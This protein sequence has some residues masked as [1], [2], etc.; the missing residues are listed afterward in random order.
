MAEEID[1]EKCNFRN[2]RSSVTLILTLDLV[3]VT[4][5]HIPGWGLP[6]HQIKSKSGKKLFVDGR[7]DVGLRTY[8]P[9]DRPEFQFIR[10]SLGD[11]LIMINPNY[12]IPTFPWSGD[13]FWQNNTTFEVLKFSAFM[14]F[15][16]TLL[17]WGLFDRRVKLLS[18]E[19]TRG[20]GLKVYSYMRRCIASENIYNVHMMCTS[21]IDYGRAR[22]KC[23][24]SCPVI[25]MSDADRHSEL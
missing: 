11:N 17:L 2:F 25:N 13:L 7:T 12:C 22:Q 21:Q 10:S 6:T 5:V 3:E 4:L 20:N 1:V 16:H 8:R 18:R 24:S 19:A 9:T 15:T 23:S 14:S